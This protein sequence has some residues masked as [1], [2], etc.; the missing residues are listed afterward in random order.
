M[1]MLQNGAVH[2]QAESERK[3][4]SLLGAKLPDSDSQPELKMITVM[5]NT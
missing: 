2:L 4:V 5:P 1:Q 3:K